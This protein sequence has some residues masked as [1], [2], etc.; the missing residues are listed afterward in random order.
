MTVGCAVILLLAS[1]NA[2]AV[3]TLE[4]S[5]K[6]ADNALHFDGSDIDGSGLSQQQMI[7]DAKYHYK[8][9]GSISAHGDAVKIYKHYVFMSWY[10]G[11]KDDRHVMLSRLDTKTGVVK[12]IKFPHQHTGF[13]GRWWIGESHNTIGIAVSPINGSIHMVYDMHAYGDSSVPGNKYGDLSLYPDEPFK[14]DFFRYSY[15]LAGAAEVADEDFT[16]EKQF[17]ADT[18]DVST[19]DDDYKHLVMTGELGD[20]Q[21]FSALTYPK[22]FETA[23]GDLML[24][25]RWGG[26][27]NGAYY[28]NQYDAESQKWGKFK[29]FSHKNQKGHGLP[30]NW[31]LYGNMKYFNGKL[32]VGFQKRSSNNTDKFTYQNGIYYAYLDDPENNV[33]R[34]HEGNQITSPLAD[35]EEIK[36]FEPGDLVETV[37]TATNGSGT[38]PGKVYIV[39]GFD[40]AMT[41][42]GDLHFIHKV[43]D[44][45]NNKTVYGHL[46]KAAGASAFTHAAGFPGAENIY[47]AGE[48]IY[49]IG[50]KDKKPYVEVAK[51][52][53]TEFTR[54]YT[55]TTTTQFQHGTAYI[56]N[57][58]VYYYL[59]ESGSGAERPLHLQVIDLGLVKP[60]VSFETSEL[61]VVEGYQSLA[62]KTTATT[63]DTESIISVA[64]YLEGE[65]ISSLS[66]APY[67]WTA[68]DTKLKQLAEGSYNIKAVVTDSRGF[69]AETTAKINVSEV[70]AA[71]V[72]SFTQGAQTIEE[73][74]SHLSVSV[75]ASTA[76]KARTIKDVTFSINGTS[77]VQVTGNEANTYTWISAALQGLAVGQHTVKAIVEDSE[78]STAEASV[79]I[80]VSAKSVEPT[81]PKPEEPAGSS[82]SGGSTNILVIVLLA[83]FSLRRKFY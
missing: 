9:G 2:T 74:Y 11:G 59:M 21:N 31:G 58:K 38:P 80:T 67:T 18:S 32:R 52:G 20:K 37:S 24:Y 12:T 50:L 29:A 22:F 25:M 6:V 44:K 71:P 60:S 26:N 64:L 83:V 65:L 76:M 49:I 7:D 75:V 55:D 70:F 54:V 16:L 10:R 17:V 34:D 33:W 30:Y 63:Q 28:Y 68:A 69:T 48:N 35:A 1:V 45:E 42:N 57:G 62:I 47:A 41:D 56:K 27:N 15:S 81:A 43:Q 51:G 66:Q 14:N 13:Q 73:G 8:F 72:I 39:S 23:A 82:G 46:Y 3:V 36:V 4:S 5:T 79:I 78:G 53:T 19:G 77:S 61:N 40:W